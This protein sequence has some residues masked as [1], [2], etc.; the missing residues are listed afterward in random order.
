M[1]RKIS[2]IQNCELNERITTPTQCCVNV[3]PDDAILKL[4][5]S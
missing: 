3:S 4:L 2:Q 1:N 5:F